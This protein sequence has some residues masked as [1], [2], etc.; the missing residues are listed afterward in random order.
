MPTSSLSEIKKEIEQLPR[1]ELLELCV[2][3]G[4]FKAEN[5]TL[6]TYEL[7]YREDET[8]YVETIKEELSDS[9]FLIN[10]DSYYYMKKTIRKILKQIRLFSRLSRQGSTEVELL[11]FFCEQLNTL[12]P[13]L[14]KREN[15]RIC[16]K[17]L[18]I[19]FFI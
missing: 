18:R 1:E 19:V 14:D 17:I 5:K 3:I 16:F 10:T 12:E 2:R 13:C 15:K 7:F 9:L 4:R 6:L 8:A 11:I